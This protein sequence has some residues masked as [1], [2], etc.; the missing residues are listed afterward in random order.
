MNGDPG[1]NRTSAWPIYMYTGQDRG[2]KE[3][4]RKRRGTTPRGKPVRQCGPAIGLC[5]KMLRIA[6]G[7]IFEQAALPLKVSSEVHTSTNVLRSSE[8]RNPQRPVKKRSGNNTAGELKVLENSLD[9]FSLRPQ[10]PLRQPAKPQL[11]FRKLR[12]SPL[13]CSFTSSMRL[14]VSRRQGRS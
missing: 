3:N 4:S 2:D 5:R 12:L 14:S 13:Q 10:G 9:F 8:K 7:G 1:L 11:S 6:V